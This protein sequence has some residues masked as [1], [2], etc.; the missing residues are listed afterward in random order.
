MSQ[1]VARLLDLL[2][3]H[4]DGVRHLLE[5]PPQHLLAH[6]LGEVHL[7]ELVAGVLL[8]EE[9]RPLGQ[10]LA[11]ALGQRDDAAARARRDREHVLADVERGSGLERDHGARPVEAVD[12]VDGDDHRQ[13]RLAQERG[14]EAVAGAH[15]LV[16]VDD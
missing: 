9:E 14:E 12:L 11:E 5:R 2:D 15:A 3:D 16:A 4:L 6:E 10:Q 13:T 1:V 8:G 7:Q